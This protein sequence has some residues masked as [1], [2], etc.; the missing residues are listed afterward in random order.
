MK[1][2]KLL[3]F[4]AVLAIVF[5]GFS[6]CGGGDDTDIPPLEVWPE[7]YD[8]L[9]KDD[10]WHYTMN[11]DF[12]KI[13]NMRE[14][15]EAGW[16]PSPHGYRFYEYWCDQM[17]EFR[18]GDCL[19]INSAKLIDHDCKVCGVKNGIFTGGIETKYPHQA[20]NPFTQAFGFFEAEVLVPTGRGM[21]SAFWLQSKNINNVGYEGVDGTEIDIYESSF[22]ETPAVTGNAVHFDGYG[23]A[24]KSAANT[25]DTGI[26]LYSGYHKY[27]LLWSPS[28]YVFFVDG[29]EVWRTDYGG[30]SKTEQFMRLTVE[31]RDSGVGPYSRPIGYFKNYGD[32]RNEFKIKR[33][34]VF[35]KDDYIP[36]IMRDADFK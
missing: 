10:G 4:V 34:R 31:I 8:F 33:A 16:Y 32:G 18:P 21:W 35:Q 23:S 26:D 19:V 12:G 22:Y 25:T 30:V 24:H 9:F 11:V 2:K 15:N 3:I 6:G 1:I 17:I 28:E 14:L 36:Y 20:D 13:N 27:A 7:E 5:A 29:L